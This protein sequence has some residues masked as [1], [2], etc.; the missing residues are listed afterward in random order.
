MREPRVI[1]AEGVFDLLAL[2][3]WRL[4]GLALMGTGVHANALQALRRFQRVY[5]ALDHDPAGQAATSE[6]VQALGGR[7][8]PVELPG[9]KDVA[10]LLPQRDG[11]A[12]FLRA[13]RA[14]EQRVGGKPKRVQPSPHA[15]RDER[16][17]NNGFLSQ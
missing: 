12:Q 13:L 10:E 9:V 4:P 6:L 16:R 8:V 15:P 3:Q 17:Q 1:L 2:R 14:A 7:A 11:R 5:L